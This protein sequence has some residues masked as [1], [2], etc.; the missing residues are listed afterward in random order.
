MTQFEAF[1][2]KTV[3]NIGGP[4]DKLFS[5]P[6]KFLSVRT[7]RYVGLDFQYVSGEPAAE[8][9]PGSPA[10]HTACWRDY[11]LSVGSGSS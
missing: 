5:K 2:G 9:S 4:Y 6:P 3:R 10:F 8:T 1:V 11:H 7:A